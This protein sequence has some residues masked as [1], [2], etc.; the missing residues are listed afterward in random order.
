MTDEID[1]L[2]Q[3]RLADDEARFTGPR[4]RSLTIGQAWRAFWRHPSPWMLSAFLLLSVVGRLVVGRGSWWE[5]LIPAALI[6]LFPAIEWVIHVGILHWRP[7][8][9]AGLE[10]DSLLARKHREHHADPRDLPLVFIPW[11]V[12]TWLLPAYVVIALLAVPSPPA[13]WSLLVSVFALNFGYEW[14]HYLIHS[15]YR[16]RSRVY[17][18]VWRNHRLHHYKNEHYWFTVTSSGTADRLFGTYPDPET[19]STSATA[20]NLHGTA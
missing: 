5:L 20:K 16:P 9:V 8:R 2:A 12:L 10:V 7:R 11:Q 4:R 3:E 1:Q 19:V 6:A 13:A 17:R 15:D 18:A 14:T